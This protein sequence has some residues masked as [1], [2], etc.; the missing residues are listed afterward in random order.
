MLMLLVPLLPATGGLPPAAAALRPGEPLSSS[1]NQLMPRSPLV[2]RLQILFAELKIY[3]GAID[4]RL[5]DDLTAAVQH[6]QGRSGLTIDGR[7]S[8]ELLAHVEFKS[9]AEA[10]LVRLDTVGSE[11]RAKARKQ[12]QSAA[13]TRALLNP[14]LKS[15]TADPA[16]NREVCF[17][18]PTVDCLIREAI[19][20][21]KAVA[22]P[23]FRDWTYGEIAIVQASLGQVEAARK[24]AGRVQDPR[25]I[26]V[27]LRNIAIALAMADRLDQARDSAAIIPDNW[28][29]AEAMAAVAVAE[30]GNGNWPE[31]RQTISDIRL[32]GKAA[33]ADDF[34]RTSLMVGLAEKIM[35][36]GDPAG[37]L[38][39]L[40]AER[41]QLENM[42]P[43]SRASQ[44]AAAFS[45]L[46]AGYANIDQTGQARLLLDREARIV[47]RRTVSVALARALARAGE[48]R[49]AMAIVNALEEARYRAILLT[50]IAGQQVL[51]G[52]P[53]AAEQSLQRA[54]TAV[55]AI[56]SGQKFA[57]NHARERIASG[58]LAL[59][60]FN[61][62]ERIA[63][64]ITDAAIR[65]PTWWSIARA[66]R[67]NGQADQAARVDGLAL[68][69]MTEVKSALDKVW[70][71]ARQVRM[72][73]DQKADE[74]AIL[75]FQKV[76]DVVRGIRH[77]WT[78]AQALARLVGAFSRLRGSSAGALPEPG[79]SIRN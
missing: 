46:A 5:N 56:P 19:E 16:R 64:T 79:K 21:A 60:D 68:S 72:L 47:H 1:F 11:Q 8:E 78:R 45:T 48:D 6:Y 13:L 70:L 71:F 76:L 59:E 74:Q 44:G 9:Q 55:S 4:G 7:V 18:V 73:A 35:K 49:Q 66:L 51:H 24:T 14:D 67:Q 15:Q 63:A 33:V 26:L 22:R 36:A 57:V 20:S 3:S 37:A 75:V 10:L 53:A 34:R 23:H 69:S 39:M 61:Q 29:R 58:W 27:T 28:L 32:S 30:T 31:A 52:S 38:A 41:A 77:S 62:D 65:V 40:D 42:T 50:D 43:E 25:L 2:E 12:L 54:E 17:Q